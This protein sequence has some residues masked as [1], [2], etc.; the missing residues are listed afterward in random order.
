VIK[1]QLERWPCGVSRI[2]ACAAK[3]SALDDAAWRRVEAVARRAAVVEALDHVPADE[4]WGVRESCANVLAWIDAGMSENARESVLKSAL[5]V[6]SRAA[7]ATAFLSASAA[8][9]AA[10]DEDDAALVALELASSAA[11][12]AALKAAEEAL[13]TTTMAAAAWE[14]SMMAESESADRITNAVLAALERECGI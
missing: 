4:P 1:E 5:L 12:S 14:A 3:W 7:Q 11:R 6:S 2:E 8:R 10:G 13:A 9:E